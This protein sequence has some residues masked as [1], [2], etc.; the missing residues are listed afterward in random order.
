MINAIVSFFFSCIFEGVSDLK[1]PPVQLIK[2]TL[3]LVDL[4][5]HVFLYLNVTHKIKLN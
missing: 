5:L 1:C 3:A 4:Q 2:N